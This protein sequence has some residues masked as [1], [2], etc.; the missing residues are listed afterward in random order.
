MENNEI[1]T[2]NEVIEA[3]EDIVNTGSGNGLKALGIVGAVAL[4]GVITY[5]GYKL[6][7]AKREAKKESV[8]IDADFTPDKDVESQE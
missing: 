6:I 2:N 8:I 7:K 5:K 3:A 1:M 4:V